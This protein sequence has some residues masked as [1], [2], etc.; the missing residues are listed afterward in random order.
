[1]YVMYVLLSQYHF[2]ALGVAPKRARLKEAEV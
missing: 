1:M 2:V